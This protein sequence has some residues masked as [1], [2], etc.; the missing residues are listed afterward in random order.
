MDHTATMHWHRDVCVCVTT[1]PL[2][3]SISYAAYVDFF[4]ECSTL[5][6]QHVFGLFS[7]HITSRSE[8]LLLLFGIVRPKH[9]S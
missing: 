3:Y 6:V 5:T 9:L 7:L 2:C 1:I 4:F 8:V